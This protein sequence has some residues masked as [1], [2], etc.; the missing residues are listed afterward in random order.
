MYND[1]EYF[2]NYV[3]ELVASCKFDETTGKATLKNYI[4]IEKPNF[5]KLFK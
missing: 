3:S 1:M 4:R 5:N 2:G